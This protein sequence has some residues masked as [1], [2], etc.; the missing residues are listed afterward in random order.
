MVPAT[1][2]EDMLD[3]ALGV[4]RETLGTAIQ[5]H[6]VHILAAPIVDSFEHIKP[7][8]HLSAAKD[9]LSVVRAPQD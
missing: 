6:L 4:H 5:A 7:T 1:I 2:S 9:S 3:V 8:L